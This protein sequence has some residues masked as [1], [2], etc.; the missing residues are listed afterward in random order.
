MFK[1]SKNKMRNQATLGEIIGS[2][3]RMTQNAEFYPTLELHVEDER[4][5]KGTKEGGEK[6]HH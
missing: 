3:P 4:K 5:R 2:N 6:N 1:W